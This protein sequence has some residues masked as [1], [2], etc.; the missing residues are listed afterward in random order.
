MQSLVGL[1]IIL[2]LINSAG[3]GYI[4]YVIHYGHSNDTTPEE[5]IDSFN[6]DFNDRLDNQ[7][8]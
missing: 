1:L 7:I 3:L 2:S 6:H 8:K 5:D 4:I